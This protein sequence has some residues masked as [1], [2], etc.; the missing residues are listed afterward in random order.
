MKP[1]HF[2]LIALALAIS[3]PAHAKKKTEKPAPAKATKAESKSKEAPDDLWFEAPIVT[4]ETKA[5]RPEKKARDAKKA[6]K[7]EPRY[8]LSLGLGSARNARQAPR[9]EDRAEDMS[10]K[11]NQSDVRRVIRDQHRAIGFCSRRAAKAG[12]RATQVLLRFR[13]DSRGIA[14]NVRVTE[15]SGKALPA[16]SRCMGHAARS[17]KFPADTAGG[18]IEYPL[19]LN[20][21]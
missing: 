13:V 16:M 1:R 14:D 4:G 11:L 20:R 7:D 18:E 3:A 12:E 6:A 19:M 2:T 8:G 21:R 17:W 10:R 5:A 15:V 9:I